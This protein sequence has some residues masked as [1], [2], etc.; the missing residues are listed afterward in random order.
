MGFTAHGGNLTKVGN[1]CKGGGLGEIQSFGLTYRE[2]STTAR[3]TIVSH[4]PLWGINHCDASSIVR[5]QPLWGINH[6][7]AST[8]VRPQPLWSLN[9]C[10]ASIDYEASTIRRSTVV[11]STIMRHQPLWGLNHWDR[12]QRQKIAGDALLC[13]NL[14]F[15]AEMYKRFSMYWHL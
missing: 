8:I 1:S 6:C 15:W 9:H 7:E 13:F 12:Q 5:H 10:E 14:P 3:S 4:Q 2:V 11:R